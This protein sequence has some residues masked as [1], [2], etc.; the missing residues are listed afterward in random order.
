ML[1]NTRLPSISTFSK[2]LIIGGAILAVNCA[3]FPYSVILGTAVI[4]VTLV[5]LSIFKLMEQQRAKAAGE[6]L[7][8]DTTILKE[9]SKITGPVR[10]TL[11]SEP[12]ASG[13]DHPRVILQKSWIERRTSDNNQIL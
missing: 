11:A 12:S 6:A 8:R 1:I 10:E 13:A 2:P 9:N 3:I 4:A 7:H 5:A